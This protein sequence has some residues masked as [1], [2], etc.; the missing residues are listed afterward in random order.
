MAVAV[1]VGLE[2]VAVWQWQ[3]GLLAHTLACVW[4]W[5]SDQ[6]ETGGAWELS[7]CGWVA[8]AGWQWLIDSGWVAVAN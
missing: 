2:A 4:Q 7:G 6:A 1:A 3:W 5:V 8:V